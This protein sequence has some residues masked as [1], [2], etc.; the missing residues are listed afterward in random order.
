[1]FEQ[2]QQESDVD[3]EEEAELQ[4]ANNSKLLTQFVED[5]ESNSD[6]ESERAFLSNFEESENSDMEDSNILEPML[7]MN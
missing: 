3:E 5:N 7:E 4:L 6:N 2:V 1:M